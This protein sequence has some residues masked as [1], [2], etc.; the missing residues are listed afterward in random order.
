MSFVISLWFILF[1]FLYFAF[2][3]IFHPNVSI[4]GS[5]CCFAMASGAGFKEDPFVK[6]RDREWF[7][8]RF[9]YRFESW[10]ILLQ[11]SSYTWCWWIIGGPNVSW[12]IGP[13]KKL[14][15]FCYCFGHT[16]SFRLSLLITNL[17]KAFMPCVLVRSCHDSL[18]S[19]WP[20]S[21]RNIITH[22]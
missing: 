17:V 20:K 8:S 21:E 14:C 4:I 7:R 11:V 10:H 6:V 15:M 2:H 12:N 16:C 1:C 5:P 19:Q 22:L 9:T 18:L 13:R 3:S